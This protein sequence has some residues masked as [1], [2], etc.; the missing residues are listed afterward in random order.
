MR[1]MEDEGCLTYPTYPF[2]DH[3]PHAVTDSAQL[4]G[5]AQLLQLTLAGDKSRRRHKKLLGDDATTIGA[6]AW[7]GE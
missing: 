6:V 3:N 4:E 7:T 1:P 2:Y 5:R